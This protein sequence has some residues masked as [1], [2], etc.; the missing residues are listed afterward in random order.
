MRETLVIGPVSSK[1]SSYF[2]FPLLPVWVVISLKEPISHPPKMPASFFF[3]YER[4]IYLMITVQSPSAAT[5]SLV[6]NKI[7]SLHIQFFVCGIAFRGLSYFSLLYHIVCR[8]NKRNASIYRMRVFY[9][10][11]LLSIPRS[12]A[13][14]VKCDSTCC[15]TSRRRSIICAIAR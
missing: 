3:F 7:S 2:F 1:K 5:L 8:Q 12:R 15:R 6:N 9:I 14:E 4:E 11:K 10:Y 13:K